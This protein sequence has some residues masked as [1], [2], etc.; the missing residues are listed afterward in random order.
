MATTA[1][2]NERLK[3]FAQAVGEELK[4]KADKGEGG[5]GGTL[6]GKALGFGVIPSIPVATKETVTYPKNSHIVLSDG[7]EHILADDTEVDLSGV[8][9]DT[10]HG[11]DVY[12]WAGVDKETSQT[13]KLEASLNSAVYENLNNAVVIGG[14]HCLC[15]DVGTIA[16]HPLSD[17]KAGEILANSCW[18]VSHRPLSDPEGMVWCPSI[19]KWVD[20]YL[21]SWDGSKLVSVYE[22]IIAD[23]ASSELFN[24]GKFAEYAGLVKKQL[25]SYDEFTVIAKGSNENTSIN[26][27]TDPVNTGGHKD[28]A[29]RR[30][31]SDFGLEDCCGTMLQWTRTLFEYYPNSTWTSSNHSLSGYSNAKESIYNSDIDEEVYNYCYGVLRQGAAGGAYN[32]STNS[33]SRCIDC[34]FA[35]AAGDGTLSA[36][37]VSYPMP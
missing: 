12:V 16:D 7:T 9:I 6:S 35:L 11:K 17:Y 20:I 13:L 1:T 18:T 26:G 36:R 3:L 33:G 31:I 23:G 37:L 2:I 32:S 15:E 8:S 21:P 29:N 22:G 19:Q 10:R 24:G 14:F 34:H 30:M 27:G 25:I 28:S 5:G 4:K